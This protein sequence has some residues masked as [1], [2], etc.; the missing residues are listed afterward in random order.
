M[1]HRI[2]PARATLHGHFSPDLPPVLTI[3]SGDSVEFRTLDAGWNLPGPSSPGVSASVFEPRDAQRDAGHAL[4]GPVAIRGAAPGMTLEVEVVALEPG[5]RGWNAAGGVE[6]RVNRALGIADAERAQ[7]LWEVDRETGTA[8]N[9]LG[10]TVRLQPFLGVMGMP[11]AEPGV[12][13]TAPPRVTGGNIDCKELVAGSRL[14]LPIA[15]PGGLFST[16]DGHAAQGDGEVSGT[17]IECAM[18][19]AELTF[20][21]HPDLHLTTPR[22]KTASGWITFGF[23]DDLDSA[24]TIALCDMVNLIV[25]SHDTTIREALALASVVVDLR[26]TQVVNGVV[27]VHALL[28]DGA[29]G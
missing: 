5:S 25:E 10:H 1:Q 21:L 3:D 13:R 22:A 24:M 9:Q 27:G 2:E 18:D 29:I 16:G 15:V 23:A 20:H 8:R 17:A 19:R 28:A 14:Y 7:L 12:H 11:P 4:C 6:S 26:V